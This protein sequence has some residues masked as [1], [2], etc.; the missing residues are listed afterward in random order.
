MSLRQVI[1]VVF[2]IGDIS[3]TLDAKAILQ[4]T[5]AFLNSGSRPAIGVKISAFGAK[6]FYTTEA[7]MFTLEFPDKQPGD[8]VR[9]LV[10]SSNEEGIPLEL[11]NDKV[12]AQVRIPSKPDDDTI[13]IIVCKV[14]ERNESAL[15]YNGLIVK[16]INE[17]MEKRLKQISD[18]LDATKLDVET[19]VSLQKEK[20]KIATER[21]SALS[22]AE[23]QALF[24][25]SIN[26]DKANQL[27]KD[28]MIKLDSLRDINA[29]IA[30][31][32]NEILLKLYEE[33]KEKAQKARKKIDK[34]I[35]GYVL[36]IK[37]LASTSNIF[38]I[39]KCC[40][41]LELICREQDRDISTIANCFEWA[42]LIPH[43]KNDL[44]LEDIKMDSTTS[45]HT[46]VAA[47]FVI[48]DFYTEKGITG[49]LISIIQA[50]WT[51]KSTDIN[52]KVYFDSLPIGVINFIITKDGNQLY[53]GQE[54]VSSEAKIN[55]FRIPLITGIP[56]A[57]NDEAILIT[58][59]VTDK[60]GRN[61]EGAWVRVQVAHELFRVRTDKSGNYYIKVN[62][63]N[64][65]LPV[66]SLK[67]QVETINCIETK[68]VEIPRFNIIYEDF[69]LQCG[70]VNSHPANQLPSLNSLEIDNFLFKLNYCRQDKTKIK[71]SITITSKREDMFISLYEEDN[72]RSTIITSDGSEYVLSEFSL[73]DKVVSGKIDKYLIK[74]IPVKAVLVFNNVSYNVESIARLKFMFNN[75]KNRFPVEIMNI[76]V[77]HD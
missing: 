71:F 38:E 5:V 41:T 46:M 28:A 52:G 1:F 39:N 51:T 2:L 32:D 40:A 12:V 74:D 13:E 25:A 75:G 26:L 14:G 70:Q 35:E 60:D 77:N 30:V 42:V 72:R 48:K 20:Y 56:A 3:N 24:I 69:I 73:G 37:L 67:I 36:K 16:N 62:L 22:K 8:K 66:S 27:V 29:A 33:E 49:A 76:R 21:D 55:I 15:R 34:I 6:D 57:A 54:V 53:E 68:V 45:K 61:I 64:R 59:E 31:L 11:V 23:E 63:L 4:G 65:H 58:G 9:I 17:N 47:T 18:K 7:G 44:N 19:I 43:K 50:G 10:G